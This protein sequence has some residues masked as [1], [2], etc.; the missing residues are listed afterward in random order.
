MPSWP[1]RTT[2]TLA[3]LSKVSFSRVARERSCWMMP[4]TELITAMPRNIM[5][6]KLPDTTSSAASP[7]N[8][9]LK[10]VRVFSRMI[11]PVDLALEVTASLPSP[12]SKSSHAWAVVSPTLGS[13]KMRSG[14]R[15]S[16]AGRSSRRRE[17]SLSLSFRPRLGGGAC[18]AC[19]E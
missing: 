1:S 10:K 6:R 8:T 12:R 13:G 15:R 4:M 18:C 17:R 5:S 3:S 7:T 16:R 14:S 19:A 9:R 2:F 11:W